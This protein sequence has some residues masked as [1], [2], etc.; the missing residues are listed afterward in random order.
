MYDN[1][2]NE[3]YTKLNHRV[4]IS[5]DMLNIYFLSDPGRTIRRVKNNNN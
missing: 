5:R 1:K 4:H 3:N 2:H